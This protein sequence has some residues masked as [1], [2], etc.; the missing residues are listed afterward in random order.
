MVLF[1]VWEVSV[2]PVTLCDLP[3]CLLVRVGMGIHFY[4][5]HCNILSINYS[6]LIWRV[7]GTLICVWY[8]TIL[9]SSFRGMFFN[10]FCVILQYFLSFNTSP[11]SCS[12]ALVH[13][14]CFEARVC[15]YNIL[16]MQI[17]MYELC[18]CLWDE[19]ECA[20]ESCRYT[21]IFEM[22]LW[23]QSMDL[24][25]LHGSTVTM[26]CLCLVVYTESA[27][28]CNNGFRTAHYLVKH[29]GSS[30]SGHPKLSIWSRR[31]CLCPIA[32]PQSEVFNNA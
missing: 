13:S 1:E 15:F 27:E 2:S 30:S 9:Q 18:L 29:K 7:L 14:P 28:D 23:L 22:F 16:V 19:S 26:N 5:H 10:S 12:P 17:L 25:W 20:C 32:F 31:K 11:E 4:T 6:N 24:S 8:G 3:F 21:C